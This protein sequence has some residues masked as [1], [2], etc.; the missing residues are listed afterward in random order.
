MALSL[1]NPEVDQLAA[2]VAQM[3]N[4][5]KTEAVRRA[6]LERRDRLSM[7]ASPLT[8]MERAADILREIRASL[9]AEA[10]GRRL[11]REE[12][13]EILGFGPDGV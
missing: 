7:N 8:R 3:A 4:E 9:P 11:T 6:L 10:K 1:K 12:E 5:T 13:D 2:Q